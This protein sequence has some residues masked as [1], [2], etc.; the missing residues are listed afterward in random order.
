[1]KSN[2]IPK[3]T[4]IIAWVIVFGAMAP[5]LDSTMMNI[6]INSLVQ[7]L[8]SSV[9]TVQWTITSYML[10]T[11]AAVPFSSWLLNK[12]NGKYIFLFE[13]GRAHV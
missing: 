8:H 11:G 2:K 10:A 5:L 9:T 6:A 1:M 4:L 7:S 3:S 13:I 12:Y